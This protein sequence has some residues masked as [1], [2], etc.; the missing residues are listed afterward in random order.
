L[1][2]KQQKLQK[3]QPKGKGKDGKA[4]EAIEIPVPKRGE[5]EELLKRATRTTK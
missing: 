4:A 5:L 2:D 3:T 1:S